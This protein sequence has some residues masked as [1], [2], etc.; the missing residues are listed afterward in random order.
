MLF[1]K[2]Q[3]KPVFGQFMHLIQQ[4]IQIKSRDTIKIIFHGAIELVEVALVFDHH[5]FS[6]LIELVL[7]GKNHACR[8]RLVQINQLTGGNWYAIFSEGIKQSHKHACFS[9][10]DAT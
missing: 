3:I 4:F 10:S 9:L 7:I 8:H 6:K 5:S 1:Q 2:F